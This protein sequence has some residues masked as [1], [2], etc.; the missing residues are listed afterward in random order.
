MHVKNF[1][2]SSF[3]RPLTQA[4]HKTHGSKTLEQLEF[5]NI[6]IPLI[7][8]NT[9]LCYTII[10]QLLNQTAQ[11]LA[12]GCSSHT[13]TSL[14][15]PNALQEKRYPF[16][17]TDLKQICLKSFQASHISRYYLAMLLLSLS[18]PWLEIPLEVKA[19]LSHYWFLWKY[20]AL[21]TS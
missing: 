20:K 10:A 16:V 9:C 19:P 3:W 7:A 13:W 8:V 15:S 17:W 4:G 1:R 5:R 2:S 11:Q 6:A 14:T 12:R 21:D 18:S